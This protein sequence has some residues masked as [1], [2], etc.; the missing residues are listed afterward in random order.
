MPL[1]NVVEDTATLSFYAFCTSISCKNIQRCTRGTSAFEQQVQDVE[2]QVD[3]ERERVD[4][5]FDDL[6]RQVNEG[7]SRSERG[8][9]QVQ[10]Q[11]DDHSSD[12]AQ[13]KD[14]V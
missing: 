4:G 11:L 13:I 2:A 1:T 5:Q 12:I 9:E 10:S 8:V 7:N 6:R 3:R 14:K